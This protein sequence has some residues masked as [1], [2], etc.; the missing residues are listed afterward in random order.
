MVEQFPFSLS[1]L[2]WALNEEENIAQYIERAEA[3]LGSLTDDFELI[4]I[5]DGSNDNTLAIASEYQKTRPWLRIYTNEVNRGSGYNTKRA[6]SLAQKDYLFWQTVDWS[7]EIDVFCEKLPLL[8]QYDVLQGVRVNQET[9]KRAFYHRSDNAQKA[10]ISMINYYLIRLLFDLP[11]Q[12]YQNVTIYPR[13]L[14]QSVILETESAFTNPECLLKVWWKGASI[15][16]VPVKFNARRKGV[17]K[18]TR[19]RFIFAAIQDIF[20]WWWRWR[21]LGKRE[22]IQRGKISKWYMNT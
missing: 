10:L 9:K 14:I 12:D 11:L 17:A 3:F 13:T 6:I 2:G 7:Y 16:E 5:N 8:K 21:I 19:A 15:K 4:L 20:Y 18:G 22:F 1:M